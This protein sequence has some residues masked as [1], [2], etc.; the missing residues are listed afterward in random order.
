MKLQNLSTSDRRLLEAVGEL[1]V[2]N[3][4]TERRE[5]LERKALGRAY[6][7][8]REGVPAFVRNG[9]KI[10]GK[11]EVLLGRIRKGVQGGMDL[12]EGLKSS[13]VKA[14]Y[15]LLFHRMSGELDALI[16]SFISGRGTASAPSVY[17]KLEQQLPEW[18]T[19]NGEWWVK[20]VSPGHLFALFFQ[21]RRAF[22][23]THRYIIGQ[24]EAARRLR[25]QVWNSVLT[26]DLDRYR[27]LL[28]DRLNDVTTLITGPSGSGKELVARAIGFSRYLAYDRAKG[29]FEGS[30]EELHFPINLSALSE[31]LIESELF[32]HRKGAFTGA[33]TDRKGYFEAC[34]ERGSIF[35]DE[36]GEVSEGI[37]VKLLRVLQDRAFQ[38]IGETVSR[39]FGGKVIAATNR[40]LEREMASGRFRE[41]FY[42]RICS[43]RIETPRLREL[44]NGR[45]EELYVLLSYI[46]ERTVGAEPAQDLA[47]QVGSWI[48]IH[49]GLDYAWPGNFR[50]LE[51]CFRSILVRGTYQPPELDKE[52]DDDPL[53]ERLRTGELNNRELLEWYYRRVYD[54]TGNLSRAAEALEVDRRTVKKYLS[55]Q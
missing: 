18:L 33:L 29:C 22:L 4:Y 45:G 37:Q 3:P 10:A 50:E 31:T 26:H 41:D 35:L 28:Y 42:F 32:G 19:V 34:P 20:P 8:L 21:I 54:Q 12:E 2:C 49:L 51:Q 16:E 17:R 55:L 36:I 23:N 25:A 38:R 39:R 47:E 44:L 5:E 27:D 52:A 9:E 13:M 15:F 14:V 24:S 46:A 11:A 30:S 43:D 7:D 40:D 6:E 53:P 1:A 48:E